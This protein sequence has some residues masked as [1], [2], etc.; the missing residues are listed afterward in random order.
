MSSNES[1]YLV[2]KMLD[3]N[4]AGIPYTPPTQLWMALLT[5]QPTN[6]TYSEFSGFNYGRAV[7]T[8]DP[9]A[10]YKTSNNADV[11]FPIPSQ[12]WQNIKGFGIFD[13]Q[14]GGNPLYLVGVDDPGIAPPLSGV[15]LTTGSVVIGALT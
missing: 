13:A 4:L 11:N 15:T 8:F 2:G 10:G 7:V 12:Q 6:T 3:N 14:T 1:A 9:Q 5:T